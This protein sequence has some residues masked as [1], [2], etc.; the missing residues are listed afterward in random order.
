MIEFTHDRPLDGAKAAGLDARLS[1]LVEYCEQ[2]ARECAEAAGDDYFDEGGLRFAVVTGPGDLAPGG[3][4][5]AFLGV[6]GDPLPEALFRLEGCHRLPGLRAGMLLL[7]IS[8][9]GGDYVVLPDECQTPDWAEA[10]DDLRCA[11]GCATA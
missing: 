6:A 4:L 9:T 5:A 7:S 8:D 2:V 11:E 1:P 10:L 3:P